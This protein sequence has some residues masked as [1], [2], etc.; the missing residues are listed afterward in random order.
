[1]SRSSG[2]P[3]T[4]PKIRLVHVTTVPETLAFLRPA[5]AYAKERA[6]D[7]HA[8]SSPGPALDAFG[9]NAGVAV[10]GVPMPRRITPLRDLVALARLVRVFRRVRPGIVH[11]HTP[12]GGLLG[13]L[14]AAAAGVPARVYTLHGLPLETARGLRRALLRL[15][16]RASCSLAHRVH[17]VS[18]SVRERALAERLCRAEKIVVPGPG[19]VGG[20]DAGFFAPGPAAEAEGRALRRACGIPPHGRVIAFVGRVVRDKGVAELVEAWRELA[21]EYPEAYLLVAGPFEPQDPIPPDA[22]RVLRTHPRV[23]LAGVLSSTRGVYAAAEVVALPTWREGFP[24]VPLEAAAM[25]RPVVGT[26]VTGCVEAVADGVTGT[27]VPPGDPRALA[28]AIRAYLDDP[29]RRERHGR[30]GRARVVRTFHPRAVCGAIDREYR[31]LPPIAKKG[32]HREIGH[33][34]TVLS[35]NRVP[36][37]PLPPRLPSLLGSGTAKDGS[38]RPPGRPVERLI[39]KALDVAGA[40]LGLIVFAPV[41]LLVALAVRFTMGRPVLFRHRRPGFRGKPFVL[42]KFRTMRPGP[43]PDALRVTRLGRFLRATSLDEL[44]QLWNVL[45]G[46]MSLVGPRPL[47]MEYLKGYS[48]EQARRHD[49]P[50]GLTGWAQVNGRN[51]ISWEQKFALDLWY[52]DHWSLLLDLKIL[53]RTAARAAARAG[54]DGPG[55]QVYPAFMRLKEGRNDDAATERTSRG[56]GDGRPLPGRVGARGSRDV[57]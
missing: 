14:A 30:A 11:A 42:L 8:V 41:L 20:V 5:V 9:R 46:D 34:G 23:R 55:N 26:R 48:A 45:R 44:P 18:A 51:G 12:K 22:E 40:A 53:V 33:L 25:E 56:G 29:A 28:R 36:E 21:P 1:M 35:Q 17:A 31:L 50:P 38:P 57:A 47:L 32:R 24:Q 16:E 10:H 7:V 49:V 39:K 2:I 15:A 19:T 3:R 6:L 54:V 4:P 52:V 43:E 27:L 37:S 13:T